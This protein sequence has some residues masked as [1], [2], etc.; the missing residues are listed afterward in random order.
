MELDKTEGEPFVYITDK[1]FF[2]PLKSE[3]H[4][5]QDLSWYHQSPLSQK[6]AEHQ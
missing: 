3:N 5:Y 6:Q 1:G 2:L 4:I